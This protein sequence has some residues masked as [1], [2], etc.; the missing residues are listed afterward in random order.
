[1]IFH[2]AALRIL[3]RPVVA[4]MAACLLF[5]PTTQAIS[6]NLGTDLTVAFNTAKDV[7]VPNANGFT[8][9]AGE[10]VA[11]SLNFAPVAGTSLTVINNTGLDF[12]HGAFSNLAQG[13]AVDLAY[14]GT[15]YHFVANY[16][17]GTGNDLVLHWAYTKPVA[18]GWNSAG[19]LGNGGAT[20]GPLPAVVDTSGALAG[21]TVI[22]VASGYLHS[23]ALCSDGTVTAW[24]DNSRGQLGNNSVTSSAEPKLVDQRGALAGKTVVA[25]AAGAYSSLALCADGTV[26]AWGNNIVDPALVDTSGALAGKTV[27]AIGAGASQSLA[28]CSDGTIAAWGG[29]QLGQLGNGSL[30]PGSAPVL[31]DT[32]G[33]LRGK[34]V[35]AVAGGYE[36]TLALGADGTLA[37]WGGNAEGELGDNS[38]TNSAVPLLVDQTGALAGKTVVA[39]AAGIFDS[40]ALC[41]DG[42][43]AGWGDNLVGQLGNNSVTSSAVPTLADQT[44]ALAG[45]TVVAIAAGEFSCL[46]L[47]ADGT[48]AAWGMNTQGQLGIGGTG[49]SYPAPV[50]VSMASLPAGSRFV[51]IAPGSYALHSLG[52]IALPPVPRMAVEQPA[53][54]PLVSGGRAVDFGSV[55][56]GG[57]MPVSFTIRSAGTVPLEVLGVTIVGPNSGDFAVTS[58]PA[59][60]VAPGS[61]TTLAVTFTPGAATSRAAVLRIAS[62]DSSTGLFD[63]NLA[64]S[65]TLT[66]TYNT[67]ADAPLTASDFTATGST[68]SFALNFVPA[69]GT[70]L[71]VVNN[72]GLDF[73]H[74]TFDN[75]AQGQPVDLHFGGVT[76]HFVA[77]YYGGTGNDLVLQWANTKPVAWGYNVHGELGNNSTVNSL[78]PTAVNTSGPLAGKT[79]IAMAAGIEHTIA[80]CAD[81]SLATWGLNQDGLLGNNGATDSRVPVAVD[82]SGALAGKTVVAVAAGGTHNMALCSDGT[83]ATW[84]VNSYGVLG[85]GGTVSSPVPVAVN[86][87]GALGGK[88]VIAVAA[89]AF[90]SLAL[91]SDGTLAAW[92][93]NGNGRLGDNSTSDSHTPV[94]VDTTGPLA[95]KTVITMAAGWSHSMALCSDGTVTTWGS[96]MWGQLGNNSATTE[97][98]TPMAVDTSGALAGKKVVA[99]AAGAE[100]SLALCSDG[101]LVGW[102][103]GVYGQLGNHS[104]LGSPVP[105][106]LNSFGALAGRTVVAIAAGYSNSLALCSDGTLAAWGSTFSSFLD[107]TSP[108]DSLVPLAVK[109]PFQPPA[110]RF[111][112]ASSGAFAIHNVGAVALP[113]PAV[114]FAGG[115]AGL[116]R[117]QP[118]AVAGVGTEGLFTATVQTSRAFTGKLTLDGRALSINGVFDDQGVAHFGASKATGLT[119]ARLAKPPLLVELKSDLFD[120]ITGTVT[121]QSSPTST[122]VSTITAD[123][124]GYDGKTPATTMPAAYL[125]KGN[126]NGL[127]TVILPAK[128]P[129]SQPAGFTAAD[130]PQGTG[131]GIVTITK[132]GIASFAGTLADGA[133]VASS[134]PLALQGADQSITF[135]L[136]AQLYNKGGFISA[137]V[138]LDSANTDSDL[139]VDACLVHWARPALNSQ[140]YPAGWPVV[141]TTDMLGSKY[142]VTPGKSSLKAP[143]GVDYSPNGYV[144]AL[145]GIAPLA[146]S[147]GYAP[148]VFVSPADVASPLWQSN[149]SFSLGINRSTGVF[150][151][152]FRNTDGTAPVYQGILYQKG[153]MAGGHGFYLTTP[154]K[155]IDGSGQSGVADVTVPAR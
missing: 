59:P 124:A 111:V 7:P 10:G 48:L 100:H 36:Q 108:T 129:S 125:G 155:V 133:A 27:V 146:Q 127:F 88:S 57:S 93:S 43:V 17:G 52:I 63:V 22:A 34:K 5:V 92:G 38:T 40:L 29:N 11:L 150:G 53:G 60:T 136:F 64:G 143:G 21:R 73:I 121:Q 56:M 54:A 142:A 145:V 58:A 70:T 86:S 15:T 46:A 61:S 98:H 128:D 18:W 31:V 75:L 83:V 4:W 109:M 126:A 37:A 91:C 106:A 94:A 16:Y 2:P 135:P 137:S 81:G 50:G 87:R 67:A 101:T 79:V 114:A 19:Q 140:Y 99:V 44:G 32:S 68:V 14:G 152:V 95:G 112:F 30:A 115:F 132:A 20:N 28:L 82:T 138:T 151:G 66:A 74:G 85:D 134:A 65:G 113:A 55:F 131:F 51:A 119:I 33:V 139:S 149:G 105:V 69:T 120:T 1:M 77:N 62:N 78:V 154:P 45:K 102:G 97:S 35:V 118:G 25:I 122:A 144:Y 96:N 49:Y 8:I 3:V 13:Q 26:A 116:A 89:G 107:S 130:Y 103:M 9:S 123:K 39:V 84:G 148:T 80:L 6:I 153:A 41:S 110:S 90:H 23:L 71:T 104:T 72:T 117:P 147:L 47:C 24:G 42:T 12:I 76:Y 141:I